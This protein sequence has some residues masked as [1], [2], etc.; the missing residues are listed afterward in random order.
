M[1]LQKG[2]SVDFLDSRTQSAASVCLL[3]G[4]VL[5]FGDRF[6]NV[7]QNVLNLKPIANSQ[8]S[9]LPTIQQLRNDVKTPPTTRNTVD[10]FPSLALTRGVAVNSMSKTID[11][12]PKSFPLVTT[13]PRHDTSG[14]ASPPM[15]QFGYRGYFSLGA[16]PQ[17][18]LAVQGRPTEIAGNTWKYGY[19]KVEFDDGLVTGF[20]NSPLSG[21]NL[22]VLMVQKTISRAARA[23]WFEMGA[24]QQDVIDVMG[25]P[26]EIRGNVW[27]Y[28]YSKIVFLKDSVS[29]YENSSLSN[30]NLRV[31]VTSTHS[32]TGAKR[33][34]F[35]F[36]STKQNVLDAMGTPTEISDDT[37]HYGYS[38][39]HFSDG[40]VDRYE[41]SSLS[42]HNLKI[43]LPGNRHS[44]AGNRGYFSLSSTKQNVLDVMGTPTEISGDTWHYGYS[45]VY[46]S[47]GLVDRYEN[48]QLSSHNLKILLPCNRHSAAGNR[49]YFSIGSTK[50]NV[51]DVM[52]TPTEISGDTWYYGYSKIHFNSQAV[53][54]YDNSSLSN[55]NLRVR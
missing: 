43:L 39:V 15:S 52:G 17:E 26:T 53:I 16:S 11:P 48:S 29:S 25:T 37:W 41:N 45:K 13:I 2:L 20:E 24:S 34:F 50:Q 22:H 30:Y 7:F 36:G 18:V 12:S 1:V 10:H 33:A 28:G 8:P 19:S 6:C 21:H 54:D 32:S 44:A 35:T 49:G 42:N 4:L 14:K 5:L 23:G 55:C 31:K 51:L 47:D 3:F 27:H 46:F 40:L 9:P 38:K